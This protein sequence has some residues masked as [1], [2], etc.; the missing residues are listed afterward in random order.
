MEAAEGGVEAGLQLL[1][2]AHPA[3]RVRLLPRTGRDV[4]CA[5]PPLVKV[6]G[7]DEARELARVAAGLEDRGDGVGG[8]CSGGSLHLHRD[9][10]L[11]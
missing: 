2:A 9:H 1:G 3:A 8:L 10:R 4:R 7:G 11:Y 6:D 5:P